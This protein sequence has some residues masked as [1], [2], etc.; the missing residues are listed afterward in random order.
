MSTSFT[1][2]EL[3]AYLDE[4]LD[5][6]RAAE[7]E[8]QLRAS[9]Q[10]Q[11]RLSH[12]NARRNSGVH[13]L[14]EIWRRHRMCVPTREELGSYLLGVLPAGHAE[15]IRFRVEVLRCPYTIAN[16]R[17]L[18]SASDQAEKSETRRQKIFKSSIGYLE[19]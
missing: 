6:S 4:E 12:I 8:R 18:Q 16:L 5:A 15:Y 19:G 13:T 17:D 10:L 9:P 11:E 1:D 14:G 3:D 2:A 7:L